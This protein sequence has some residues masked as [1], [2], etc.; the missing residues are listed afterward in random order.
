[1][2]APKKVT[3]EVLYGRAYMTMSGRSVEIITGAS[4]S[5]LVIRLLFLVTNKL[6]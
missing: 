2:K 6:Y 1:M 5:I 3:F 4:G